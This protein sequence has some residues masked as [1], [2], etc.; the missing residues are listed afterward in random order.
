M[1]CQACKQNPATVHLTMVVD[2]GSRTVD[3][4]ESC[5]QQKGIAGPAGFALADLLLG[6]GAGQEMG[7]ST[8]AARRRGPTPGQDSPPGPAA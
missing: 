4:C 6:L 5:A 2:A 1:R 7:R 3:L 8:K